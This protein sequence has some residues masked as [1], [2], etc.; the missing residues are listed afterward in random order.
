MNRRVLII[1]GIVVLVV[2]LLAIA[3]SRSKGEVEVETTQPVY[4]TIVETVAANGKIQP[5]T[6][7][8]ISADVSGEITDLYVQEGDT[9]EEGQLLLKID[10]DLYVTAVDRAKANL[11]SSRSSLNTNQ[12]LVSQAESRFLEARL[13]YER[14]K[15]LL[16]DGVISQAEFDNI[17]TT[18]NVAKSEVEAAKERVL[19]ARYGVQNAQAT[20]KEA[21]KNLSLTKIFSPS[22]GVV[23]QLN[24]EKGERVVG[25]AQ[26]QG[27]EIMVIS[28]FNN[29]EVQVD[30]NEN[31]ILEVSRGNTVIVE[32][33]AYDGRQFKGIVT[34]I[35]KSA[36]GGL[37][38]QMNSD[39]ITNF[40]VKIR[41]LKSSYEDL[42]DVTDSPFLRGMSAS[43]EIQTDVQKDVLALPI[44][45]VTTRP[46][47]DSTSQKEELDEVVFVK[48]GNQAAKQVVTTGIQDNRYIRVVTGLSDSVTVVKGPY[49]VLSRKLKDG[50]LITVKEGKKKRFGQKE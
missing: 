38:Q 22:D 48:N 13:L 45:A 28:N 19:A 17:S 47:Y 50:D 24:S 42:L 9:V 30:V 44:E 43:V 5:E 12:A 1:I 10:E 34:E 27:T 46:R 23:S 36:I 37:T 41:I 29:M 8:K 7:V 15:K 33:D 11:N 26:M 14:N 35:A 32:V 16:E 40:E 3:K 20:L 6:E 39:Q 31:D 25:T 49:D 4:R 18:Y 21:L 2:V